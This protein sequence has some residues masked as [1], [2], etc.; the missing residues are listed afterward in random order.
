L[1]GKFNKIGTKYM[2]GN[3]ADFYKNINGFKKSFR[4]RTKSVVDVNG[5]LQR[6]SYANY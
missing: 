5:R 1:D 2:K 3:F 4:P 6:I